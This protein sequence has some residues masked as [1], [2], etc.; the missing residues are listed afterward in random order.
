MENFT[1]SMRPLQNSTRPMRSDSIAARKWQKT[2]VLGIAFLCFVSA[3]SYAQKLPFHI[4]IKAGGDFYK[5]S[6][7]SFDGKTQAGF[8]GGVFAE[9]A[10]NHT[11]G[12]QPEL[13]FSQ[14]M[15]NT[16]GD[17][18]AIYQGVSFTSLQL[19]Y[20]TLPILVTYK[21]IPE[22]SILLGPQYSYLIN[23][24]TGLLPQMGNKDAFKKSDVSIVFGGQLNLGKFRIGAR[25]NV[26]LLDINGINESDQWKNKGFQAYLG[27]RLF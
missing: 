21:P 17:F 22:L 9:Y 16:S 3:S 24:T 25:Y 23:Q 10:F 4:G 18:N 1:S 26:G 20:V 13:N 2:I 15:S 12:L 14:T 8:S 7:R 5:L 19:N 11:W 27:Y 6:G